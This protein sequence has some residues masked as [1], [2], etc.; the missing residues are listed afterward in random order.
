MGTPRWDGHPG[1]ASGCV[2][3]VSAKLGLKDAGPGSCIDCAR[4]NGLLVVRCFLPLSRVAGR[5]L[6]FRIGWC[7]AAQDHGI[8]FRLGATPHALAFNQLLFVVPK[9]VTEME[10][11]GKQN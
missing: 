2:V 5:G 3:A 9:Q 11:E 6:L 10:R 8:L 1:K 7:E 4:W